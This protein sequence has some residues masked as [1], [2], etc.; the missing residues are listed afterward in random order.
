MSP[1]GGILRLGEVVTV[2]VPATSANLGPGFDSAGLALGLR[3]SVTARL[4]RAGEESAPFSAQVRVSGHGADSLPSDAT[5][6]IAD[7]MARSWRELGADLT[8]LVLELSCENVIPHARGLG[9][10]AAAIVGALSAAAA[11][12]EDP[13][14]RPSQADIFQRASRLEGHPDNVAPAVF[15]G[16]SVSWTEDAGG[17]RFETA[18][19][20]PS[21]GVTPV[22]GIPEFEVKTEAVRA[23]LPAAVPHALAA[24]N[25][26]RAALLLLAFTERPELLMAATRDYLHQDARASAMPEAYEAM[27]SLRSASVAA[28]ISGAGPTV[29]A[30]ARDAG[31]ADAASQ[32]FARRGFAVLTP[33]FTDCGARVELSSNRE[34]ASGTSG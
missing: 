5:H 21:A 15:G 22:V 18:V 24:A 8:G 10:S 4:E 25:A 23:A 14:L 26:G 29:I 2:S 31:E 19:V 7:L 16:L 9:S 12:V 33:E 3:D 1:A 32:E 17:G 11:L 20:Q 27:Q 6:L 13:D 34:A 28:A 30:L